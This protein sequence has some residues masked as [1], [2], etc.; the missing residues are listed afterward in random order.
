MCEV[1]VWII[2]YNHEQFI[3]EAID[4]VLM[5]VTDFDFKIIIGEDCSTDRTR[6]IL[7]EYK[8]KHP[9]KFDLYLP[10]KN[11]G[12][13]ELIRATYS[14][15]TGKYVASFDGDDYWTDPHKLQKQY[16]F[17][18]ANPD[19]VLHFHKA[20]IINELRGFTTYSTEAFSKNADNSLE[21]DHFLDGFN[22]ITTS[23]VMNRNI[24]GAS[25]PEWY[26]NL[27]FPDYSYYFLLLQYG[28][29]HYSP[30]VMSVYRVHKGGVWS[31][32]TYKNQYGN[33]I[34]FYTQIHHH[35]PFL[36]R[37]KIDKSK[38]YYHYLLLII[39]IKE[40]DVFNLK[41][42]L[43]AITELNAPLFLKY[44]KEI[45]SVSFSKFILRKTFSTF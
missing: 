25:L 3:A 12:M 35:L 6:E 37:K 32:D 27:P 34:N 23:S 9:D 39:Y 31:G 36:S 26:F 19:Y 18:E 28:K 29:V 30:D 38:A 43:K 4:S 44:W 41:N 13:M 5:Q 2:T 17:L 24:L 42:Q 10:E 14:M 22:P 20:K 7:L 33:M 8:E 16:D 45:I 11:I 1:S 40:G 15:C 21:A